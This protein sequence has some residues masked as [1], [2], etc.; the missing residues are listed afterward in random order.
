MRFYLIAKCIE[1]QNEDLALNLDTMTLTK[2]RIDEKIEEDNTYVIANGGI[3]KIR[4][5]NW[6]LKDLYFEAF[7]K[8]RKVKRG[9]FKFIKIKRN[10]DAYIDE[11]YFLFSNKK[12][13]GRIVNSKEIEEINNKGIE[14]LNKLLKKLLLNDM[15]ILVKGK[16]IY[17]IFTYSKLSSLMNEN[18]QIDIYQFLNNNHTNEVLIKLKDKIDS[19]YKNLEEAKR[20]MDEELKKNNEG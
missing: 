2:I 3:I 8:S 19:A 1:Q 14:K 10:S 13:I 15:V 18:K 12:L 6:S 20:R 7:G 16:K 4:N 9:E 5:I 17:R 11:N